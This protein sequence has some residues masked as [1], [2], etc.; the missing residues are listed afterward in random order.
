MIAPTGTTDRLVD[1]RL[2]HR[3][4]HAEVLL[5]GIEPA[6]G[7]MWRA[8]LQIHRAHPHIGPERHVPGTLAIEAVRQV[9]V[10]LAHL[11]AGAPPDAALTLQHVWLA[12]PRGPVPVPDTAPLDLT[13]RVAITAEPQ[14]RGIP[15]GLTVVAE[16]HRGTEVAWRAGGELSILSRR[17]YRALRRHA[18]P[19]EQV[20]PRYD[21]AVLLPAPDPDRHLLGYDLSDG[22][23]FDHVTDHLPGMLLVQA[24]D[25]LR[26][27]HAP[28]RPHA[29]VSLTFTAFAE[30]LP[31]VEVTW[32]SGAERT[33]VE[34]RQAGAL[35]ASGA[36]HHHAAPASREGAERPVT[37]LPSASGTLYGPGGFA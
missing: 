13:A 33:A 5:T 35:V 2:V 30:Y 22:L 36:L 15:S 26:R 21:R 24:M 3:R 20:P 9:G 16:F 34:F 29:G 37:D 17:H 12:W 19:P 25:H 18:A 27:Q 8:G 11:H 28:H 23:V 14:R 1:R 31:L 6:A 32:R 7:S 10:A 4:A